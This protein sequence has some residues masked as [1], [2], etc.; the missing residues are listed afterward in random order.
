MKRFAHI[1]LSLIALLMLMGYAYMSG[2]QIR[3]MRF[4]PPEQSIRSFDMKKVLAIKGDSFQVKSAYKKRITIQLNRRPP[5]QIG[6]VVSFQIRKSN[7]VN[8]LTEYHVW[9]PMSHWYF[10]A[11]LSVV[12][13][14]F[15]VY[16][17]FKMFRFNW[18]RCL[19]ELRLGPDA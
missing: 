3:M 6:D 18:R 9:E 19:F 13:V 5:F 15:V 2:K 11:F 7:G 12:P 4:E 17:F 14:I 16:L 8:A 1:G 10:K